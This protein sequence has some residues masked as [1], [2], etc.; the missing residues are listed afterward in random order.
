MAGH[1]AA[2]RRMLPNVTKKDKDVEGSNSNDYIPG[3]LKCRGIL[4]IP[5]TLCLKQEVLGLFQPEDQVGAGSH[6]VSF[7]SY[8]S[9][10]WQ[11]LWLW[12]NIF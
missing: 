7:K 9:N 5:F 6:Y 10:T 12:P 3:N 1:V 8:V 11:L 2:G 4:R